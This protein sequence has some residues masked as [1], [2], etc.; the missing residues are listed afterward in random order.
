MLQ[1]D[2]RHRAS[3]FQVTRN[4][5]WA[6]LGRLL[7]YSGI[8]G[9][10]TQ[11]KNSYTRVILPYEHY[12][13]RVSKSSTVSPNKPRDSQLNT[14]TNIQTAGKLRRLSATSAGDDNDS[15]PPS[16]LT[17]TSSPLSD[18]SDEGESKN[19][20]RGRVAVARMR[21][22]TR[23]SPHDQSACE[24][25]LYFSL[26]ISRLNGDEKSCPQG[27]WVAGRA[28]INSSAPRERQRHCLDY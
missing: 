16:P 18:P 6:D 12:R 22:N 20:G 25:L 1:I 3:N 27:V 9:L 17:V 2:Y 4:K 24:C 10:S 23:H 26:D 5:K 15:P 13:E 28:T 11:M 7:G 8:P 21:R 14:N 19:A